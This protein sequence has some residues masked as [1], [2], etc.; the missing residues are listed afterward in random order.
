MKFWLLS[1]VTI[2]REASLYFIEESLAFERSVQR[3]YPHVLE[4]ADL[5]YHKN[6][7]HPYSHP[8][9]TLSSYIFNM[10]K[11]YCCPKKDIFI[12]MDEYGTYVFKNYMS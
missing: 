10:F 6:F 3:L 11:T 4:K 8:H 2:L 12:L 5:T 1:D 7:L 9:C